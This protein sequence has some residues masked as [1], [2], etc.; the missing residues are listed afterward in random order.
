[1]ALKRKSEPKGL[2][3]ASL[4]VTQR[5]LARTFVMFKNGHMQLDV[6]GLLRSKEG[7]ESVKRV[8]K[9]ST[10]LPQREKAKA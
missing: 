3:A 1:M 9:Q 10:Y 2:E 8:I 4:R 7:K 6:K 5:D